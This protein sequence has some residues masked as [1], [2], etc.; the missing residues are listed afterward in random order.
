MITRVQHDIELYYLQSNSGRSGLLCPLSL[1]GR[2][3]G[4]LETF[5]TTTR[6]H[7]PKKG[8]RPG[9]WTQSANGFVKRNPGARATIVTTLRVI[10]G[11]ARSQALPRVGDSTLMRIYVQAFDYSA[12]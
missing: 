7:F 2:S 4:A 10:T 12:D 6:H 11:Q 3:A 5:G 8:S 9:Y 1:V